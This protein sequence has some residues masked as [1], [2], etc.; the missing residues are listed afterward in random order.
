MNSYGTSAYEL[1]KTLSFRRPSGTP[2]EEYAA[3]LIAEAVR[4][5]GFQPEVETFSVTRTLPVAAE[6]TLTAPETIS[7]TVTGFIDGAD[8][9]EAGIEAEFFYLRHID[10]ISL[11]RAPGAFVLLNDR[12]SEQEYMQLKEAGI[13]GYLL[14]SGTARDNCDNSDL[15]TMRFRDCYR[16]Y[17]AVPAFAIRMTDAIDLLHHDPQRV[18]FRLRTQSVTYPSRNLVVEVRGTDFPEEVILVGA[19]YDS[20]EFSY[21]A[22]DNGAGVV[23]VWSLLKYLKEHPPHR[24]VRAVFFGSEEIG[25]K[26][27]RAYLEQHPEQQDSLL[28]MVNVDVGGSYLGKD[29]VVSTASAA[30]EQYLQGLLY[31]AGY[32]ARLSSGVMSSDSINF[33]D[34]GIPSISLGQFPPQGAGYMHTRYD[35]ISRISPD[36][37]GE[38]IRF[39]IFMVER[40]T[41]AAVFPIPRV[42]PPDLRKKIMDYF[43]TGLSHTE[44]V[45]VFPEE[46]QPEKPL[47]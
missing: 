18:W 7:Y 44:T 41:G 6:L 31:E 16:R 45:S 1:L 14:M 5:I 34:Y 24:T 2:A 37:L 26:G 29:M 28:A 8:T 35:N 23:S 17:G 9:P 12:P 42:I 38:E 10:R 21:G 20:T 46:P 3:V 43:G 22:W 4:Q 30:T 15:D 33:S 36:V 32:S 39:L 40:I 47:F 27:S 19:H 11:K 25:L 13:V